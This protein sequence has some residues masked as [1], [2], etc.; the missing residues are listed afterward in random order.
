MLVRCKCYDNGND[1]GAGASA[2]VGVGVGVG[3][4]LGLGLEKDTRLSVLC[5]VFLFVGGL[6]MG[7]VLMRRGGRD[8]QKVDGRPLG[9]RPASYSL[10]HSLQKR[11]M[12]LFVSSF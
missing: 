10:R 7:V 1:N 6:M 9:S 2:G 5:F 3:F 8:V 12:A 11:S 4:L